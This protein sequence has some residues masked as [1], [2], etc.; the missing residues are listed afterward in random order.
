LHK[1]SSVK[2]SFPVQSNAVFAKIPKLAEEKLRARGWKF[3]TDGV[4]PGD[5][6]LM[7]SWDTT[8]GDVVEFV[9][10]LQEITG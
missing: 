3:N 5:S 2:I 1:I 6:R 8:P 9:A 7:C 4:V 10:D